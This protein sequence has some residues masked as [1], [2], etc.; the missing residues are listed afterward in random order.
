MFA[1]HGYIHIQYSSLKI[2]S[3]FFHLPICPVYF[4]PLVVPPQ[5]DEKL[6]DLVQQQGTKHWSM[7]ARQLPGRSGKQCRERWFNHVDPD[8]NH[9]PWTVEEDAIIIQVGLWLRSTGCY[10]VG[11]VCQCVY[12]C[13]A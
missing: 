1:T 10:Y 12:M 8:I 3:Y 4:S 9:D 2:F 5:E 11:G 7:V 13:F 6:S